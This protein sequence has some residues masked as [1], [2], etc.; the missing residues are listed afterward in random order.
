MSWIAVASA[1]ATIGSTV[2]SNKANKDATQT[3]SNA[4][5][6]A[7]RIRNEGIDRGIAAVK[8]GVREA[9]VLYGEVRE[10]TQPG[11]NY[12]R[13]VVAAPQ[14]LTPAQRMA[15]DDV[16][17]QMV[18]S[19]QVGGSGLRGSGRSFTD[20]FRT[21]E[22]DFQ[23]RALDQN[24]Q[25]ADQAAL[26]FARP[27]FT[28]AG[29]QASQHASMGRDVGDAIAN[30]GANLA[31]A[32]TNA[33]YLDANKTTANAGNWVSG[34]GDITSIIRNETKDEARPPKYPSPSSPDS[35]PYGLN[36]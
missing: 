27:N 23:L 8:E 22:N 28:A 16:R 26:E 13:N 25:R 7:A 30:Q 9:D 19:S 33:G 32:T 18:N 24:R 35:D 15:L 36:R 29:N 11:V 6:E 2:L 17:R 21:V 1:A 14:T 12:L 4:E 31:G 10:Q 3:A 20:A 5:L 34:L